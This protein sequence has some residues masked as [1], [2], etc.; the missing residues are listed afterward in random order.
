MDRA[1]FFNFLFKEG[2]KISEISIANSSSFRFD[3]H[4]NFSFIR[5]YEDRLVLYSNFSYG[6]TNCADYEIDKSDYYDFKK[7]S[8]AIKK[9]NKVNTYFYKKFVEHEKSKN[10]IKEDYE[11]YMKKITNKDIT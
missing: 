7:I 9:L 10:Q 1:R 5:I 4:T 6:E 3:N 2:F 11:S 8:L